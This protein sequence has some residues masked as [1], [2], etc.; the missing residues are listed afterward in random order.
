MTDATQ[1]ALR[2][3]AILDDELV[4]KALET[5]RAEVTKAWADTAPTQAQERERLYLLLWGAQKFEEF[6]RRVVGEGALHQYHLQQLQ[7]GQL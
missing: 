5:M 6:F 3:Q 4:K 1:R 2:A 7:R